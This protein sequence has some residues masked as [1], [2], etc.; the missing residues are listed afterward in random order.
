MTDSPMKDEDKSIVL[1]GVQ[2]GSPRENLIAWIHS[3]HRLF[4]LSFTL[5]PEEKK[6]GRSLGLGTDQKE[7]NAFPCKYMSYTRE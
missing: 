1:P 4:F 6:K 7:K 2:S 3:R 5:Q